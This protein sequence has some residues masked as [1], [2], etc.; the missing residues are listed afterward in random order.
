MAVP[1]DSITF[2]LTDVEGSTRLWEEDAR[3]MAS[4]LEQHD[5]IV[6]EIVALHDGNVIKSKGEGDSCFCV[7]ARPVD[8]ALAAVELQRRL[9]EESWPTPRPIAVR[10][11]IHSG[12]AQERDA[13]FYGPVVNRSA[14][15]RAIA[16]GGQSVVSGT[17]ADAI[18]A[19]LPPGVALRDLGIHRL[20]DL[21]EPER[22]FQ[23]DPADTPLDFPPLRSLDAFRHNLPVQLTTFV[24]REAEIGE[25]IKMTERVRLVTIVGTGG[26]G[27]TRLSLQ[28]AADLAERFADGVWFVPLET[29]TSPDLVPL[30]VAGA[31]G[32]RETA[33]RPP[34]DL[35]AEHLTSREAL[36]LI[37]NCEHVAGEVAELAE[38][39]LTRSPKLRILATSREPLELA[40]EAVWRIPGL[41]APV[42][43][44]PTVSELNECEAT[45]LFLDR[46]AL[47]RPDFRPG[48]ADIEPIARICRRLDGIPLAIEL[49]AARLAVLSPEEIADRLEDR[50]GLL[51]GGRRTA[52]PRQQTLRATIEWSFDLLPEAE[53]ATLRRLSVFAGGFTVDSAEAVGGEQ[54]AQLLD[55]IGLLVNKSLVLHDREARRYRMLETILE[56]GR[57]KLRDSGES[58]EFAARHLTWCVDVAER[59]AAR[60][61]GPEERRWFELLGLEHDNFRAALDG[62]VAPPDPEMALRLASALGAFWSWKGYAREGG[63]RL[64]QAL[65][66]ADPAPSRVRAVACSYA[67]F[68]AWNRGEYERARVLLEEAV[69]TLRDLQETPHLGRALSGLAAVMLNL[70]DEKAAEALYAER[71]AL[72]EST[73]DLVGVATGCNGLGEV[74]RSQRDYPRARDLYERSVAVAREAQLQSGL[75]L[76]LA[77]LGHALTLVG[78][79]DEARTRFEESIGLAREM[80]HE[81]ILRVCLEGLAAVD[82]ATGH[83]ERAARL[84]GAVQTITETLGEAIERIDADFIGRVDAMIRDA[85]GA[86]RME[87]LH[88]EGRAISREAALALALERG[89]DSR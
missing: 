52:I 77:N 23:L 46:A 44:H 26:V 48:E 38:R 67:G 81:R 71:I 29:V 8:A 16:H 25:L 49:A 37:D 86:E 31:L 10:L 62:V 57:E 76:F 82:A 11:A 22:V 34:I 88:A 40:G 21:T 56:F 9:A 87:E 64:D 54:G 35:I 72:G 3:L 1:A 27:K 2:L 73:G 7:F 45:R 74:A 36:L 47:V 58:N 17:T 50:F 65:A 33:D 53:R 68:L 63:L 5:R 78:E 30:A 4:A 24:G 84:L 41:R 89:P 39:L 6:S 15:L 14:R 79:H 83:P 32:L 70:G 19:A 61:R 80:G 43:D 69:G 28:V 66:A 51:T 85:L 18:R 59:A 12:P 75:A 55:R 42:S 20:K 60:L 13:D